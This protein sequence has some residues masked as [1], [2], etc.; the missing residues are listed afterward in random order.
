MKNSL[1]I[2][3]GLILCLTITNCYGQNVNIPDANFKAYLVGNTDINTNGDSEIQVSEANA[4][5]GSIYCGELSNPDFSEDMSISDLTGIEEFTALTE[6][7]CGGH[8]LT[9][10][11]V[12]MNTAL[13]GLACGGNQLTSLDVSKNT[14]LTE[15][16]C[17][18]N[19]LISLDVSKNTALTELYCSDNNLTS[20]DVSKNTALTELSCY[21]NQFICVPIDN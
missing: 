6:L 12:S 3:S 11:D 15:L 5:S 16:F 14:A 9:S 7:D 18:G 8:Q 4:F 19:Q 2:I 13:T 17:S 21:G 20:L 1:I 10:L